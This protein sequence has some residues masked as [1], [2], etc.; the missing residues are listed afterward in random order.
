MHDFRKLEV[1]NKAM[2]LVTEV[3]KEA[4]SFPQEERFGLTSQIKRSCISI[5]SNIAEGCGRGTKKQFVHFLDISL[6]SAYEL[7]T[8]III[9]NNL[10]Y[11]KENIKNEIVES[12][13]EISRMIYG[14]QQSLKPK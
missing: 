3:Y 8:Q 9:G 13:Q 12:I 11:I 4:N 6:A 14:L 10:G 7:E 1:W 2:N 5:P